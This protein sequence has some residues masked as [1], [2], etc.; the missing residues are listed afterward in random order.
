MGKF[1]IEKREEGFI[2]FED[3]NLHKIALQLTEEAYR[4]NDLLLKHA[5]AVFA[6]LKCKGSEPILWFPDEYIVKQKTSHYILEDGDY[7]VNLN[8]NDRSYDLKNVDVVW[9]RRARLPILPL[10]IHDDDI[11]AC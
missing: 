1:P 8:S 4:H 5:A 11:R 6:G 10:G 2:D 9:Y 7:Y 3:P